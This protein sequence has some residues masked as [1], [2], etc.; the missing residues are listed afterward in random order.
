MYLRYSALALAVSL[1]TVAGCKP[2]PT[3]IDQSKVI[4]ATV[5]LTENQKADA[6]FESIFQQQVIIARKLKRL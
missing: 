3:Q 6:L 5:V 2:A 1:A 4:E